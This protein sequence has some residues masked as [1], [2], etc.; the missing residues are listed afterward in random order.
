[1]ASQAQ[2]SFFVLTNESVLFK[3]FPELIAESG[4]LTSVLFFFKIFSC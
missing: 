3:L 4:P 2:H 1:M